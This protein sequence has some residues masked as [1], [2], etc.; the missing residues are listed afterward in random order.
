MICSPPILIARSE[1][2]GGKRRKVFTKHMTLNANGAWAKT[3]YDNAYLIHIEKREANNI[4]ELAE[5]IQAIEPDP[6]AMILRGPLSDHGEELLKANPDQ[7]IRRKKGTDGK[8][9]SF[10]PP[11]QEGAHQWVMLD[12]DDAPTHGFDYIANPVGFV[13]KLINEQLPS[14]FQN[15]TTFYQ[16]SASAGT[17]DG[18]VGLHLWFWLNRQIPSISFREFAKS[19]KMTFD[20]ALFTAVQ[21]HYTAA[22]IFH[23]SE[24]P[25]PERSG[26]IIGEADE[27][28]LPIFDLQDVKQKARDLKREA[29]ARNKKT[30]DLKS[31]TSATKT[32]MPLKSIASSVQECLALIGDDREAGQEGLHEP[33]RDTIFR[34]ANT[35]HPTQRWE[36]FPRLKEI[37]RQVATSR[38]KDQSRLRERLSDHALDWQLES[39][40]QKIG[41][42]THLPSPPPI[43]M[44]MDSATEDIKKAVRSVFFDNK[45]VAI[46]LTVGG[47][48]TE[49]FLRELSETGLWKE[50]RIHIYV[51]TNELG[52]ELVER[53]K[54]A[55]ITNARL[56]R[57]RM[58]RKTK[59]DGTD[60]IAPYCHKD[61][62][63]IAELVEK[64][65]GDVG[66][67]VCVSCPFRDA[68]GW[69]AQKNDDGVGLIFMPQ[70]YAF[71][72]HALAADIQV[73][74][75]AFWQ[76]GINKGSLDRETFEVVA[77][78]PSHSK[79]NPMQ[80]NDYGSQNDLF[81][82]NSRLREAWEQH[83][84]GKSMDDALREAKITGAF[85]RLIKGFHHRRADALQD[86]LEN[87]EQSKWPSII[88]KHME[89]HG[90]ARLE[91]ALW[92]IIEK[93][94]ELIEGVERQ[95][96]EMPEDTKADELPITLGRTLHGANFD[97]DRVYMQRRVDL[98][99]PDIPTLVLDASCDEVVLKQ[100]LPDI[101][102]IQIEVDAPFQTV[103]QIDDKPFGKTRISPD[104]KDDDETAKRKFNERQ[105]L[106][107]LIETQATKAKADKVGVILPKG[108]EEAMAEEGLI[109]K[110]WET[111]HFNAT[112][113]KDGMRDV[114]FHV[115]V[116][117]P[118]PTAFDVERDARGLWFDDP[119]SLKLSGKYAKI[120]DY[121]W[122]K[123][124]STIRCERV[125]HEDD[126][127]DAVRRQVTTAQLIQADRT[128]AVQRE[129]EVSILYLTSEP[130]PFPID[131]VVSLD[132]LQPSKIEVA[133]ARGALFLN[134]SDASTVFPDLWANRKIAKNDRE[135]SG[136]SEVSLNSYIE[137]LYIENE[138]NLRVFEYQLVGA[139]KKPSRVILKSKDADEAAIYLE[140]K[141][142]ELAMIN[143]LTKKTAPKAENR[144][145][146][147]V[148]SLTDEIPFGSISVDP[149]PLELLPPTVAV[150]NTKE[151]LVP[152]PDKLPDCATADE[153]T[154]QK[155]DTG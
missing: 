6:Y 51:P 44:D 101:E 93:E 42:I 2:R 62:H 4:H 43:P 104:E 70:N 111:M 124:G 69:L 31:L 67:T 154:L 28:Q 120:D 152:Q 143:E 121:R 131:Q 7:A 39:A 125:G 53:A 19:E 72:D 136:W 74:D 95:S 45:Q 86:K 78:I 91:A 30:I 89:N 32:A 117:R 81:T 12:F 8:D 150:D 144:Q 75:E 88:A 73:F 79:K 49:T 29:A 122:L 77:D 36:L 52:F 26:V 41:E 114:T 145:S 15:V 24:D 85:A 56:H 128:R 83:L 102:V 96:A 11:F 103:I 141:L 116:G 71:D 33:I 48:K 115:V 17:K 1:E 13:K 16:Y 118:E 105:K 139:G 94:L 153:E 108:A 82:A 64:S 109:G 113:G 21:P 146:L 80:P 134:A 50:Q 38:S 137:N 129:D 60:E 155:S 58:W 127:V 90:K 54:K 110:S 61:M 20:T 65:H 106:S 84:N 119:S 40:I 92:Y 9:P 107:W 130:L 148:V 142:G 98:K 97:A 23:N 63:E 59:K 37:I 22:P 123:D 55:G 10:I 5:I 66:K 135:R 151:E 14:Y 126:R 27:V 140:D 57:G 3:A 99:A 112:S 100:F 87:T 147:K 18:V 138:A 68:C 25:M 34:W 47:G 149:P 133:A 132:D 35:T 76:Q 46:R